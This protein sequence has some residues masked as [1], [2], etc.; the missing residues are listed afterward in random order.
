MEMMKLG[1]IL[2]TKPKQN[3][4]SIKQKKKERKEKSAFVK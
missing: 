1:L 3:M 2:K 4:F